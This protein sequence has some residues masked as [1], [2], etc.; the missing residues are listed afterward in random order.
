MKKIIMT[1]DELL[2]AAHRK[3]YSIHEKFIY[4]RT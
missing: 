2:F 1:R 4:N 3:E